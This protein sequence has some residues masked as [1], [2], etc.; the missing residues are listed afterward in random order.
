MMNIVPTLYTKPIKT[1]T[2]PEL[3]PTDDSFSTEFGEVK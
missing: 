1:R 3:D 2:R